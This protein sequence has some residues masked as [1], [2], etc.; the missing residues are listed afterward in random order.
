MATRPKV[1]VFIIHGMGAPEPSFADD[2]VQRLQNNVGPDADAFAFGACWWSPILQQQQDVTWARLRAGGRMRYQFARHWIVNALGD[3]VSYLSG[4]LE[5]ATR[6]YDVVHERVRATLEKVETRL[7]DP[8]APLVV[9]A[10]SLGTIVTSN[11]IWN[12]QRLGNVIT[13]CAEKT[14]PASPSSGKRRAIGQTRFQQ[15]ETLTTLI[16]FGSNIPLFLPPSPPIECIRFPHPALP[17]HLAAVARWK[18]VYDP[19]DLLGYPIADVWDERHG[20]TIED[21]PLSVGPWPLSLTPLSHLYYDRDP[22]FILLVGDE[23]RRV[24][25]AVG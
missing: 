13:P 19:A 5:G 21:I 8:A 18:N 10:H 6:A 20:T 23:L 14:P 24:L 16:T 4:Y 25:A 3:P 22:G 15:M 12:E 11:Y 17:P 2:L 1:G 9:L 7:G